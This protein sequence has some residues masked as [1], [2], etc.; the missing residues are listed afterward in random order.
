MPNFYNKYPYTDFHELNLDWVLE[1]VQNVVAEWNATKQEW[2][3]TEQAWND[4]K[5]YVENYFNTLDLQEE[6]NI[7]INEMAADGTLDAIIAPFFNAYKTEIDGIM[8]NQN[9]RIGVLESRMDEFASLPPGSTAGNAE[10]LDIRVAYDGHTYPS[11]GDAVRG[12]VAN[13]M[14]GLSYGNMTVPIQVSL[15]VLDNTNGE[16]IVDTTGNNGIT[17]FIELDR[18]TQIVVDTLTG[19]SPRLYAFYY[20]A[21]KH[22]IYPRQPLNNGDDVDLAPAYCRLYGYTGD[23]TIL[24]IMPSWV[25]AT[26]KTFDDTDSEPA[27]EQHDM[28]YAVLNIALQEKA[29][30]KSLI[31]HGRNIQA[32]T[33]A[34]GPDNYRPFS[35]LGTYDSLS[36]KYNIN[37]SV[38]DDN[39]VMSYVVT[40]DSPLYE[41]DYVDVISKKVHRATH[42]V[43]IDDTTNITFNAL[44]APYNDRW[45]FYCP[46]GGVIFNNSVHG[47]GLCDRLNA[48]V[49]PLT[50]PFN[51]NSICGYTS[52][53]RIYM[54]CMQFSDATAFKLW[55]QSNPITF[56]GYRATP[57]EE[58]ATVSREISVQ[59]TATIS[60]SGT[61]IEATYGTDI[62]SYYA[63]L[64]DGVTVGVGGTY[65]SI[66][67]ALKCTDDNIPIKVLPGT[68]DIINEYKNLYGNNFF[69]N[70]D[71]SRASY[72]PF[73]YGYRTTGGRK[74]EFDAA[75]KV[76]C[77]YTGSNSDVEQSFSPFNPGCG[78]YIKNLYMEYDNVRYA[79]HDD[80]A[81]DASG[82]NIYEGCTFIGTPNF[83]AVIGGGCGRHCTY[84]VKDCIFIVGGGVNKN[85]VSYH[86]SNNFADA[87]SHIIVSGCNGN[88]SCAFYW[89]GTTTEITYCVVSNNKF[90]Y[91]SCSPH[92]F[93]PNTN[94]NMELIDWNNVVG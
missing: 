44:P 76:V 7:K 46:S 62:K 54:T 61:F 60:C 79:V 50:P 35:G 15:G 93:T 8:V 14:N 5:S 51:D 20:D 91:I 24:S 83:S 2:D 72:D 48:S 49:S 85:C 23:G 9:S 74:I 10:L 78:S 13:I 58:T 32:G 3:D 52:L 33:G 82:S 65:D 86:N 41:G 70:Y 47:F 42:T 39:G 36:G 80:F 16:E 4:L 26:V 94:V 37:M 56:V 66:L 28:N 6:V 71:T 57:V 84:I 92:S 11:A 38:S 25:I 89:Y 40:V 73:I 77:N 22:W 18:Y 55:L 87:K 43:I 21:N 12:Q 59:G 27:L 29:A 17:D 45:R 19:L 34:P 68:Y 81:G 64:L 53:A 69:D 90:K 31:L 30:V 1:T 75:A 88:G 63:K 67:K